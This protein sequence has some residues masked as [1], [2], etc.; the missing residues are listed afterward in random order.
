MN[1]ANVRETLVKL[2]E[3]EQE[4]I[5]KE[6]AILRLVLLNQDAHVKQGCCHVKQ[7]LSC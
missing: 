4:N 1:L 7:G 2:V 6:I 5:F 3:F